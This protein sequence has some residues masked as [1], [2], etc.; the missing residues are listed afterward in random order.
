MPARA[1]RELSE[2]VAALE[3]PG[4]FL[5][6]SNGDAE[7]NNFL[8][9]DGTAGHSIDGRIVDFE[10]A[11]FA[12]AL[13]SVAW[14]HVPGPEWLTVDR[15]RAADLEATYRRQLVEAIPEASEDRTFAEA[16]A[17]ACLAKAFARLNRLPVLDARP[18]GESSRIQMV[19]TLESAIQTAQRH[20]VYPRLSEWAERV[21]GWL[22]GRWPD[23]DVDLAAMRPY[24]PRNI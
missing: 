8:V 22:R 4:H 20:H 5:A 9:A 15:A 24:T 17:G 14:I 18:E 16:M 13:T 11:A 7:P 3:D 19:A 6:L 2:L 21:A 12:H 1:E 10:F 23:A